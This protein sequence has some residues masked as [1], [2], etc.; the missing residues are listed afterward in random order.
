MS[1]AG[2]KMLWLIWRQLLS[3]DLAAFYL[4]YV[5]CVACLVLY[6]LMALPRFGVSARVLA[7]IRSIGLAIA[8]VWWIGFIFD[9]TMSHSVV[10][11]FQVRLIPFDAESWLINGGTG[12]FHE[13]RLFNA[14]LNSLLF[15]PLGSLL[16]GLMRRK[17][18]LTVACCLVLAIAI[19]ALQFITRSGP[20]LSD[21]VLFR[22]VGSVIGT[23]LIRM[24]SK[25]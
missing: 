18:A 7:I 19:E 17:A 9:I 13:R 2:I 12:G 25:K 5:F 8:S 23:L 15:I 24:T 21:E 14:L 6:Q 4:G 11:G 16:H 1:N 3:M 10:K 20:V 22:M